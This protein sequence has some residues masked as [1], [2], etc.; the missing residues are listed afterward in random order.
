MADVAVVAGEVNA[1]HPDKCEIYSIVLGTTV[2][3]GQTV[4]F[5]TSADDDVLY[6]ADGD[7]GDKDQ[8]RGVA[9]RGGG[10]GQAVPVLIRGAVEGFT[11]SG[12]ANDTLLYQSDTAG[13]LC[14]T[15]AESTSNTAVGRV[16]PLGDGTL[17]VY[18]DIAF[19]V[20]WS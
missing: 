3:A 20:H 18:I 7:D 2:T 9:L 8:T 4:A 13:A 1:I 12:I 6:I 15:G 11:V 10:A 17:V 14:T 16:F 19:N 5:D